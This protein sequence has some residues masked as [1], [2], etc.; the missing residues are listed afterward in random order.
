M[1]LLN[2]LIL[3]GSRACLIAFIFFMSGAILSLDISIPKNF[4]LSVIKIIKKKQKKN[5][6]F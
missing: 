2:S 6:I 5:K 1:K 3:L 4:N